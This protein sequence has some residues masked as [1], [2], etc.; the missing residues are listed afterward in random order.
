MT[1]R[2]E[3]LNL[4]M[5][6]ENQWVTLSELQFVGGFEATRR[7]RELREGGMQAGFIIDVGTSLHHGSDEPTYRLRR[8]EESPGTEFWV[9]NKCGARRARQFTQPSMDPRWRLGPCIICGNKQAVFIPG[10]PGQ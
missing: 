5:A 2:I 9:C 7:L 8:V 6:R 10:N 3:V 4:L 1:K